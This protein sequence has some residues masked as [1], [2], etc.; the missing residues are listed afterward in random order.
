ML[1]WELKAEGS[2]QE[3]LVRGV[4]DLWTK[5]PVLGLTT[6]EGVPDRPEVPALACRAEVTDTA[7]NIKLSA[8]HP[9]GTDWVLI[10]RFKIKR[11]TVEPPRRQAAEKPALSPEQQR[12]WRSAQLGAGAHRGHGG[13][14]GAREADARTSRSRQGIVPDQDHQ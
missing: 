12:Q 5:Y 2:E 14:T 3:E 4:R 8:S 13:T 6:H 1:F 7:I 10:D 11:S 9:S